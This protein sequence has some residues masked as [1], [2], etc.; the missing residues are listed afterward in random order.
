VPIANFQ[1]RRAARL[2]IK[3]RV[4]QCIA[5][6]PL[7]RLCDFVADFLANFSRA[8]SQTKER[9]KRVCRRLCS[10]NVDMVCVCDFQ[11]G[12]SRRNGIWAYRL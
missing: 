7:R 8:L 2:M 4:A 3:V 10:N 11:F 5:Q 12:E 9:H 6:I 1:F